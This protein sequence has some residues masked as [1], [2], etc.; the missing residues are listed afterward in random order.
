[1][2]VVS[3]NI[4]ALGLAVLS[5]AAGCQEKPSA[6]PLNLATVEQVHSGRLSFKERGDEIF[7]SVIDRFGDGHIHILNYQ[8]Q[9]KPRALEAL[10]KKQTELEKTES[11]R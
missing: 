7:V 1:M 11:S 3:F 10:R 4:L 8:G 2:K 5:G 9:T 6:F